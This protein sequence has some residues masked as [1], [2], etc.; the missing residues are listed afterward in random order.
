MKRKIIIFTGDPNSINSEIIHKTWN[1]LDKKL[2]K[3]IY[4][5]SNYN[6]IKSQFK[7]LKYNTKINKVKNIFDQEG[8]LNIKIIDINLKFQNPFSV[9]KSI[10]SKFIK[11]SLEVCHNLALKNYTQGFIN[12]PIDKNLLNSRKK[13]GV[14]EYLASKCN[15]KNNKEA[16]LIYNKKFSVSPLTTHLD[17]KEISKKITPALIINKIKTLNQW[18]KKKLKKKPKIAVLGL[19][20]HNAELRKNSEEKR[21]IIPTIKKLEKS[22]IN[23]KGPFVADTFFMDSFKKFDLLIGMYHDQ[24]LTPFKSIYKFD[25]INITIGLKYIRTSPDHG[26]AKTMI[27]KNKANPNSLIKCIDFINKSSK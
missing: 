22:G 24:V 21:I 2:K 23:I 6:L 4:F 26:T 3:R 11:N 14:T 1:K 13:I 12:C 10:A 15:I 9:K 18:Y 25:A 7:K 20:P 16:M 5:I 8:S 19:N 17:I 27:G